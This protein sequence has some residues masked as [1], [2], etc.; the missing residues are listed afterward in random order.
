MAGTILDWTHA[1]PSSMHQ[2]EA[3]ARIPEFV[4]RFTEAVCSSEGGK[5]PFLNLPHW[6][7]LLAKLKELQ[8]FL[9]KFDHMLLLGIGG[10]ALGAK[11][12]RRAFYTEQ[13]RPGHNGP[14][15]W[16]ADNVDVNTLDAFFT[17]LPPEKTVIVP[18]S[19]SG[20]T[21]ETVSQY[22]LAVQWLHDYLGSKWTDHVCA[23]TGE[24]GFLRDEVNTHQLQNVTI[25]PFMSGR[26][27]VFSA[28]GLVP[29]EF[30]GIDYKAI[31]EGAL[32]ISSPLFND[33][34]TVQSLS[35]HPA[36]KLATWSWSL[37]N[38][39]FNQLIMFNYIPS[40]EPFSDWFSHLWA[41]SLGREAKGGT[42]LTAN[43]VSA[44]HS[45]LQLYLEGPRDKGC[46]MLTCP[47]L[48]QGLYF[49]DNT[50]SSHEY[51]KQK[52]LGELHQAESLCSAIALSEANVPLMELQM[53][54]NDLRNAGRFFA[55]MELTTLFLS[56]LI[57]I[58]A[59]S[60][61]AVR[62]LNQLVKAHLGQEGL[63]DE[64]AAV[65]TFLWEEKQRQEF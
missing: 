64:K 59:T 62:R 18:V 9:S 16:V 14:W 17:K 40:W 11:A 29:A 3:K 45:H 41:Q 49:P 12:L 50:P 5:L 63:A 33:V 30:L 19:R 8:P 26:Y 28:A 25:A 46:I 42:P 27:S 34:L 56:W 32:D 37:L 36:W 55:L 7:T 35:K 22:L 48:P 2:G 10:S 21:L 23:I 1:Y 61:P 51:L 31:G 60:K 43:G 57:D 15:L 39:G 53:E 24:T 13:D 6:K 58:P 20:N 38:H 54:G 52:R 44:H 47:N 65:E 4:D